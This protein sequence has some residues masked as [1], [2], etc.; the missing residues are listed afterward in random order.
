MLLVGRLKI[1]YQEL[2]VLTDPELKALVYGHELDIRDTWNRDRTFAG[3]VVSPYAPKGYDIRKD[4]RFSW[5]DEEDFIYKATKD[6]FANAKKMWEIVEKN[7]V[8]K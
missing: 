6:D 4:F 1:P 7:R 8:K 2:I 5:E 3:L